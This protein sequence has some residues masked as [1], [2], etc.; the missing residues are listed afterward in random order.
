MGVQARWISYPKNLKCEFYS[1]ASTTNDK[2]DH[3][4]L[5]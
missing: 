3:P 4:F 5:E 1:S 2:Y